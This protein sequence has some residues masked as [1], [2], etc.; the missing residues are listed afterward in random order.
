MPVQ[1]R[2]I[3]SRRDLIL[4]PQPARSGRPWTH[5]GRRGCPL[6]GSQM[7]THPPHLRQLQLP[8][9]AGEGPHGDPGQ[10]CPW[11][12]PGSHPMNAGSREG[13]KSHPGQS[14]SASELRKPHTCQ[15]PAP[16]SG[17]RH[18][19]SS[20]QVPTC[21]PTLHS[22]PLS[23]S[24]DPCRPTQTQHPLHPVATCR[25]ESPPESWLRHNVP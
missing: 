12:F 17:H 5:R 2:G 7:M 11:G 10:S 16:T 3:H 9:Q 24:P 13:A 8:A 14:M 21:L 22:H 1:A 20:W 4:K 18:L 25:A 19:L 6:P 23:H 15:V